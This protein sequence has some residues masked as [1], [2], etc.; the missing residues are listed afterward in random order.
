MSTKEQFSGTFATSARVK[1]CPNEGHDKQTSKRNDNINR[2]DIMM[3]S[4]SSTGK[5]R[6]DSATVQNYCLGH[7][8]LV[9]FHHRVRLG[10]ECLKMV[11][12]MRYDPPPQTGSAP[13][14]PS[15][16]SSH[17]PSQPPP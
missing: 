6:H 15:T 4:L 17:Q 8:A 2:C 7:R 11:G 14:G 10:A 3:G 1:R 12:A 9:K 16:A 13:P 5:S